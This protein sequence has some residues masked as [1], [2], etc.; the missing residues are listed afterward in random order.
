ML[1]I[2]DLINNI[3]NTPGTVP[4]GLNGAAFAAFGDNPLDF[5]AGL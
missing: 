2:V 1:S 5:A 4:R 3:Q